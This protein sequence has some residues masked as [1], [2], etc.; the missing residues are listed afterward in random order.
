[1]T[2]TIETITPAAAREMLTR[3]KNNR[4]IRSRIVER[5][6]RDMK[7]GNFKTTHQGIAISEDGNILDGQHRLTACALSGVSIT[8][9]V[10]RGMKTELMD[11]VDTGIKRNYGD[12]AVL[13]GKYDDNPNLRR[14][15]TVSFIRKLI[16][17]GYNANLQP[18]DYEIDRFIAKYYDEVLG[19]ANA[20]GGKGGASAPINAAALA[21]ALCGE[22]TSDIALFYHVFLN[23]D[24]TGCFGCNTTAGF[25]FSRIILDAKTKG[26]SINPP[27]L[28]SMAQNAIYLFLRT[29]TPVHIIRETKTP[30]YPVEDKI[31]ALFEG[32]GK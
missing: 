28:F 7:A 17:L 2:I 12:R 15:Q 1:M 19:V 8:L 31:K 5:L 3:N 22:K 21:A 11:Y 4:P 16:Q 13:V 9:P 14:T 20:V 32:D 30:R 25:N 23:G 10:A 24:T 26:M 18:S 6:A 27:R 29:S